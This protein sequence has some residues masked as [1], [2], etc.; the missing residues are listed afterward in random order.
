MICDFTY[1]KDIGCCKL[2][3]SEDSE[4]L[5]HPTDHYQKGHYSITWETKDRC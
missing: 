5:V 3:G 1:R 4:V 2:A